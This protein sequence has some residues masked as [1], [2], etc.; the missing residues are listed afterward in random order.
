[1]EGLTPLEQLSLV[2]DLLRRKPL[3]HTS[4]RALGTT[5][6]MRDDARTFDGDWTLGLPDDIRAALR[7]IAEARV[8]GSALPRDSV[9]IVDEWF[10]QQRKALGPKY[11]K[12]GPPK[13]VRRSG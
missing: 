5:A 2:A 6:Y 1:V 11:L 13:R 9:G 4:V 3:A 7:A 12:A 8:Y 10:A